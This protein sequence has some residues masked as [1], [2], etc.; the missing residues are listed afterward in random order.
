MKLAHPIFDL[1][2]MSFLTVLMLM[3]GGCVV[4]KHGD[5]IYGS[6]FKDISAKGVIEVRADGTKIYTVDVTSDTDSAAM[7]GVI[8]AVK[9]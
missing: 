8:G 9:P 1:M 6:L 7:L 3:L 2:L 5:T 4:D